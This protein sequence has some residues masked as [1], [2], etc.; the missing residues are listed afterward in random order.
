MKLSSTRQIEW[1]LPAAWVGLILFLLL[2]LNLRWSPSFRTLDGDAGLYAYMGSAILDGQLPY[3][4]AW[5]L[6]PPLGFYLN[7]LAVLVLG[8][9]PWAI[10]WLNVLSL[11]VTI[12]A[13]YCVV[14]RVYG[15]LPAGAAILLFSLAVMIPAIFQGGNFMEIY[16]FLPQVLVF[17]AA[18]GFFVSQRPRWVFVTGLLTGLAFM[19]KQ[20][21]I[22][23]G[24]AAF[25][26]IFLTSLL[27]HQLKPLLRICLAYAGGVLAAVLLPA[28]YWAVQGA[29]ESFLDAVLLHG[30]AFAGARASFGYALKHTVWQ[31]FPTLLISKLYALAALVGLLHLGGQARWYLAQVWRRPSRVAPPAPSAVELAGLVPLAA[32]PLELIFASLGG[33]NF[34]HYY[35]T[36]IPAVV[37]GISLGV[38]K[39]S[40]VLLVP[41]NAQRSKP[42]RAAAWGVLV[43]GAL[44]WAGA[45]VAQ[46]KPSTDQL[47]SLPEIFRGTYRLN[48]LHRHIIETTSPN[49]RVLVWHV[50]LGI[51]FVTNRQTPSRV[52]YPLNLFIPNRRGEYKLGEFVTD[53]ASSPPELIVIQKP[54]S[55]SMPFVDEPLE[56]ICQKGCA[57][58]FSSAIENPGVMADL[59]RLQAFFKD[60]YVEDARIY[61]WVL[62][63]YKQ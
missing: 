18:Y 3:R 27:Q 47:A 33:R 53:L 54:S 30:L 51:N 2:L 60:N 36:M 31:V 16:A 12:V 13:L 34:G 19:T 48:D 1:L 23:M 17:G 10:W 35:L 11:S 43:L 57:A 55:L 15:G 26:M 7:A 61:D 49:D 6:K 46:V 40:L 52:L 5:E 21:T 29:G 62:Y 25:G 42:W 32:L 58:E 8:H 45:A 20:P 56:T 50:H 63:R 28:A 14:R 41:H 22:G 44:V 39:L 9:T 37:L 38:W 24:L 4:D 59:L